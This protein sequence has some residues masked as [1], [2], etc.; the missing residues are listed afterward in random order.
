MEDKSKKEDNRFECKVC[1]MAFPTR[2]DYERHKQKHH[3]ND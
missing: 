1:Q 3:E 2:E